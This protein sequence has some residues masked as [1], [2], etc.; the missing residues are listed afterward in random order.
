M[1][2][3]RKEDESPLIPQS[4][5]QL[6]S[7]LTR[8]PRPAEAAKPEESAAE[9]TRN[10]RAEMARFEMARIGKLVTFKG[11]LSSRE[12]LFVDGEV[13]GSIDLTGHLLTVG[14]NG[15]IR[16]NIQ[17]HS[18]VILGRVEGNVRGSERVEL[19]KTAVVSGDILTQRIMIEEGAYL[20]GGIDIQKPEHKPEARRGFAAAA[21]ASAPVTHVGSQL[22]LPEQK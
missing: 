9:L 18:V 3:S 17:A 21:P 2:K 14:P 22:P 10:A 1:W 6:A 13:E 19:R 12:D 11:E 7:A 8:E 20:K 15:R 5:A 4:P 16:A